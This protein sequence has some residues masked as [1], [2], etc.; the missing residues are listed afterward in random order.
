MTKPTIAQLKARIGS[1][2]KE[3][4]EL[5][6]QVRSLD[7]IHAKLSLDLSCSNTRCD[8]AQSIISRRETEFRAI[9][10][11]VKLLATN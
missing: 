1:L 8:N 4:I 9:L 5:R 3:A 7:E 10:M 6:I 2:E 11:T